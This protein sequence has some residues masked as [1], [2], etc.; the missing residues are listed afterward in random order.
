[1]NNKLFN[2]KLYIQIAD[3]NGNGLRFDARSI[4]I[5][6]GFDISFNISKTQEK[7]PNDSTI[8][9]YNISEDSRRKLDND[10]YFVTVYAGYQNDAKLL[11]LGEI[12][13][14]KHIFDNASVKTTISFQDGSDNYRNSTISKTF[15]SGTSIKKI[16]QEIATSMNYSDPYLVDIDENLKINHAQTICGNSAK[17]LKDYC[18]KAGLRYSIQND[19]LI[20]KKEDSYLATNEAQLI[21]EETGLVGPVEKRIRKLHKKYVS[22]RKALKKPTAKSIARRNASIAE[23]SAKFY[24]KENEKEREIQCKTLLFPEL[25]P[26]DYIQIKAKFVNTFA[27][28]KTITHSGSNFENDFYSD[29]TALEV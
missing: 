26:G 11:A 6:N 10:Y 19:K 14:V 16:I 25:I 22:K 9:I 5:E 20:I 18:N 3:K 12:S 21:S 24:A 8:E 15:V 23:A 2:R 1:M 17:Y 29:I 28:I 13:E 27:V 4:D 7:E